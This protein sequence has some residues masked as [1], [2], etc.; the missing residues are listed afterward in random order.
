M[1]VE[2]LPG[3]T[4]TPGTGQVRSGGGSEPSAFD[5][6]KA[7]YLGKLVSKLNALM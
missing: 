7:E 3:T 6:Q 1:V 4:P 2:T 5:K